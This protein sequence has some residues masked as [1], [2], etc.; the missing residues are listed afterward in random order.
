LGV[1]ITNKSQVPWLKM[2][3]GFS[4]RSRSGDIAGL[5]S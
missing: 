3:L 5:L 2:H 4:T 1:E